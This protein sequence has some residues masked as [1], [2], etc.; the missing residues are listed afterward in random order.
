[1]DVFLAVPPR[2]VGENI[3]ATL[4]LFRTPIYV[5]TTARSRPS[6]SPKAETKGGIRGGR[7]PPRDAISSWHRWIPTYVRTFEKITN[8]FFANLNK[9]PR[10]FADINPIRKNLGTFVRIPQKVVGHFFE[11]T[12]RGTAKK[13]SKIFSPTPGAYARKNV[14]N[15]LPYSQGV[16]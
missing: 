4:R 12:T 3:Y 7:E 15:I 11:D 16:R 1:M 2:V 5:R 14:Q 10:I 13:T 9:R 8:H 6:V